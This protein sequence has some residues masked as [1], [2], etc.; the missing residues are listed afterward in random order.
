MCREFKKKEI[1][2]D[3]LKVYIWHHFSG[4]TKSDPNLAIVLGEMTNAYDLVLPTW[5]GPE[6]NWG[7][8]LTTHVNS[9]RILHVLT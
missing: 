4:N 2:K 7:Q 5:M 8:T 6:V 1:L 9:P 3:Y